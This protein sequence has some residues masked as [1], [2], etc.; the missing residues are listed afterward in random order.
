MDDQKSSR[1]NESVRAEYDAPRAQRL[2]DAALGSGSQCTAD[3][4]G[5]NNTC[6]TGTGA[7]ACEGNGNGAYIGCRPGS[8]AAECLGNG[9]GAN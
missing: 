8:D 5:A 9:N 3:G 7:V 6:T 4:S 1:P 2:S